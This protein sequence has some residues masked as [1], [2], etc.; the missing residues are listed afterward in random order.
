MTNLIIRRMELEDLKQVF[1]LDCMSFSLPWSLNAYKFELSNPSS[2]PWVAEIVVPANIT[3]NYQPFLGHR[4][5]TDVRVVVCAH[6]RDS[7]RDR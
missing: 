6:G 4:E 7:F 5:Q 3:V 1:L 2:R